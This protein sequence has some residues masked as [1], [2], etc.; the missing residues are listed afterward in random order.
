MAAHDWQ[1]R[2]AGCGSGKDASLENLS[3]NTVKNLSDKSS[4]IKKKKQHILTLEEL[5]KS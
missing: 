5:K 2:E 3:F 4:K 1:A